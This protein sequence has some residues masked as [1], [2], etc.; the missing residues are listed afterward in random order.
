MLTLALGEPEMKDITEKLFAV[1][2][3]KDYIP[4]NVPELIAAIG[5]HRNQQQELQ[6]VMRELERAGRIARIKGNRYIEPRDAD[7]VPGRIRMNRQGKGFLQPDDPRLKEII[8][9]ESATS[10]ALH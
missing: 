1:L 3:R 10:T 4:S 8:I 2:R 6:M 5:L 7:L 9:P